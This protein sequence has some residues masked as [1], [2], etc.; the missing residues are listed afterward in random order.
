MVA[1]ATLSMNLPV[2]GGLQAQ[3]AAGYL[4][5]PPS[6]IKGCVRGLPDPNQWVMTHGGSHAYDPSFMIIDARLNGLGANKSVTSQEYIPGAV[7]HFHHENLT[8]DGYFWC[9]ANSIRHTKN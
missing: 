9:R 5:L 7:N 3:T 6:K 4:L 8:S 2:D 1:V